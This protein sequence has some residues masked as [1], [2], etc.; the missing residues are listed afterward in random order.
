MKQLSIFVTS[1]SHGHWLG[2]LGNEQH[3]LLNTASA[4]DSLRQDLDHPYITIDLGDFI[5][6]SSFATYLAQVKEDGSALARAMNALNYDYQLIGNHEFNFGQAYRDHILKQV[7]AQVLVSNI[8]DDAG[9][10]FMGKPYDIIEKEG[11]RIGII[12]L[13]THYIPHWELPKHYQGLRFLDAYQTAKHYVEQ[14]RP[15]VDVLILAYH[16]GYEADLTSGQLLEADTGENQGERILRTIPGIDVF[17]TGHQH[18]HINQTYQDTWTLQPGHGGEF[19]GQVTLTLD[20]DQR[21]IDKQGWL[22]TVDTYPASDKIAKVLEPDLSQ[23]KAWLETVL[24]QAPLKQTTD[25]IFQARV[26]GHPFVELLNQVQLKVTGA[27]FSGLALVN[28]YFKDFKGAITNEILLKA[29]PYYNLIATVQMTGQEIYDVMNFNLQYLSLDDGGQLI[30]TPSY[31][32]PKPKHYNYDLYSGFK[33]LVDMKAP[34]DAR[35]QAIIDERTGQALDL[36][37]T[38][39]LAISQYRA[40]GGGDYTMFTKDKISAISQIDIATALIQALQDF[41]PED[42]DKINHHYSHLDFV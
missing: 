6:G 17:L 10:V 7:A 21:V 24:G 29:Y 40:V 14:L 30:V 35:I 39:T 32:S 3:G 2:R 41:G 26:Q 27:E 37:K 28:E 12:G 18:R 38:Y 1:D 25:D 11:I 22:H 8:V 33:T 15:Q 19:V 5:Q 23:G 31:V 9:Q 13:T 42:W 20:Q 16:G 34:K 4:L 36:D